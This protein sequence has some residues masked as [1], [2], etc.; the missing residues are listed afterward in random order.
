MGMCRFC[1]SDIRNDLFGNLQ[2][3][4]L[5]C[6][7]AYQQNQDD[8]RALHQ[9]AAN[10]LRQVAWEQQQEQ[11]R[12]AAAVRE[13]NYKS[14]VL[15]MTSDQQVAEYNR[16]CHTS[17]RTMDDVQRHITASEEEKKREDQRENTFVFIWVIVSGSVI[18]FIGW[19]VVLN[20]MSF[21]NHLSSP[22]P[23]HRTK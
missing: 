17:C 6:E 11:D 14:K 5:S 15:S 2:F 10:Q 9:D 16:I 8:Q 13:D 21:F 18:L 22:A 20:I 1:K 4:D 7:R 12:R 3:C 23:I 19:G